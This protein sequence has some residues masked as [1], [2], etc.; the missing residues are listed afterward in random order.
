MKGSPDLTLTCSSFE[1]SPAPLRSRKSTDHR[2][3]WGESKPAHD[4]FKIALAVEHEVKGANGL[5]LDLLGHG[6]LQQALIGQ[7]TTLVSDLMS[8]GLDLPRQELFYP[9]EFPP[10]RDQLQVSRISRTRRSRRFE[11]RGAS[12]LREE[13]LTGKIKTCAHQIRNKRCHLANESLLKVTVPGEDPEEPVRAFD[14]MLNGKC[15][16]ECIM[17][18]GLDS[19]QP[20]SMYQSTFW[21]E[22]EQA[23]FPKLEQVSV[24]SGEPFIQKDTYRLIER[25]SAVNPGCRWSLTTNGQYK[26][27]PYI[28]EHLDRI[29]RT[30]SNQRRLAG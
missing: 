15:N 26:L 18:P 8:T 30:A 1:R 12:G 11:R 9:R 20:R 29:H 16:L 6:D 27:T 24:K 3:G 10:A 2:P 5:L 23:I 4:A 25:V 7:M 17:C 22:G 28:L 13:F 19:P 14:L 21:S